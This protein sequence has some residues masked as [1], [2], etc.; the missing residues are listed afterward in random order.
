MRKRVQF[1]PTF[2]PCDFRNLGPTIRGSV[3][4]L[5]Y[6]R[7][8]GN[9]WVFHIR[10]CLRKTVWAKAS[11]T[12]SSGGAGTGLSCLIAARIAVARVRT[13]LA[14]MSSVSPTIL[15]TRLPSC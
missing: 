11:K 5:R 10:S 12:V 9:A 1:S 3:R 8:T 4:R 6:E 14:L 7:F 2:R 15:Q 13:T